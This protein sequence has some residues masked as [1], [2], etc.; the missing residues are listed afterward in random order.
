MFNSILTGT[1][2]SVTIQE[3]LL[4]FGT[5][6]VC[7][8]LIALAYR[9]CTHTSKGFSIAL[10]II[11]VLV[12]SVIFL[13]NGN[14]G[15]GVAVA[16]SFSL[17]RFRSM[18][19]KASDI[20]VIFMAMAVGLATGTGFITYA[21]FFTILVILAGL[22][23][24]KTSFLND[25][26]AYRSLR[27]TIPEDLD[28]VQVFEDVFKKYTKSWKLNS[29]KT[30]N[31]GAMYQLTYEVYLQDPAQEKEMIDELRIRNGNLLIQS[32]LAGTVPTEL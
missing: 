8:L 29:V 23:L 24:S 3:M 11:P 18:P 9:Q 4:C 25:N 32:S 5:S 31:L 21:L 12:M 2:N 10:V 30:V 17:V 22:V 7:G 28:Y 13:V 20:A 19:G 1:V 14:L 16:G 6:M 26:P 27:I 15:V